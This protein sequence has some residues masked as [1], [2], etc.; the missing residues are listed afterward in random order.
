MPL[1]LPV[2]TPTIISVT[3]NT[4][5]QLSR[6]KPVNLYPIGTI[7]RKEYTDTLSFLKGEIISFDATNNLYHVNYLQGD[8][9][10]FTYDEV[11]KYRKPIQKYS[12]HKPIREYNNSVLFIPTKI[13]PNPVKQD[14]LRQDQAHLLQQQHKEY[15][16]LRHSALP[17][18]VW[19][20]DLKKMAAYRDLIKHR[21]NIIK[22]CWTRGGENKFGRLFQGFS[23]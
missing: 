17:G 13:C 14:Y 20:K 3:T 15:D 22:N 10:E 16:K 1:P 4:T 9:E 12:K 21:N 18:T 19:D 6:S 23:P 8:R 11:R 2:S 5:T 7:I